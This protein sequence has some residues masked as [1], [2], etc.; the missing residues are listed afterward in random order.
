MEPSCLVPSGKL[1]VCYGSWPIETVDL[2]IIN[3]NLS[4][5]MWL[6]TRGY[7]HWLLPMCAGRHGS[8][9]E[10]L[11]GYRLYRLR[12]AGSHL[13][14]IWDLSVLSTLQ[15]DVALKI[16]DVQFSSSTHN[17][18]AGFHWLIIYNPAPMN[19]TKRRALPRNIPSA[20]PL[21]AERLKCS[22]ASS[23]DFQ[24]SSTIHC[25][26]W[27]VHHP[28]SM[29]INNNNN[30]IIIIIIIIIITINI[31][32]TITITITIIIII[33]IIII[34]SSSTVNKT[35]STLFGR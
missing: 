5:A 8:E 15:I 18:G 3:G 19:S 30:N 29:I 2:P 10:K 16:R 11:E 31:T 24:A 34:P 32:I 1:R 6:F 25:R 23:Q 9:R 26:P 20:L 21:W 13:E 4:I 33:I 22:K 27:S 7:L 17:G 14:G 28:W 35:V 12:T